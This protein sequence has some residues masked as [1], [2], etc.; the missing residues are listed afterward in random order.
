MVCIHPGFVNTD[1]VGGPG[2]DGDLMIQ[3]EDVA[4]LAV[5]TVALPATAC[6]VELVVRPQRSPYR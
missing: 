3:P 1:M 6:A 2:L 4:E 5:A